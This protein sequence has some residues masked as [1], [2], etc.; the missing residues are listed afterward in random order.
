MFELFITASIPVAI[1]G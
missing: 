1:G